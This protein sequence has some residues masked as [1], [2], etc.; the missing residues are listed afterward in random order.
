[1]ASEKFEHAAWKSRSQSNIRWVADT[2][3]GKSMTQNADLLGVYLFVRDLGATIEFYEL[4]GLSIERV[5]PIFARATMPNGAMIEF[6]CEELTRSYDPNW[7]TRTGRSRRV[8]E[9]TPSTCS[10]PRVRKWTQ[11]TKGW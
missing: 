8:L 6:G 2:N 10:Y 3:E 1:M 5:S 9:P 7:P 11:P 4:L